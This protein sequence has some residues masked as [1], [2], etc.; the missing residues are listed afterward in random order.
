V[1]FLDTV[2]ALES[3]GVSTFL[4]LGPSAVVTQ[5]IAD[6]VEDAGAA[7]ATLRADR[8][9]PT[10]VVTALGQVFTR[11][12]AVDWSTYFAGARRVDLP[13]YAFQRKRYWPTV[14]LSQPTAAPVVERQ[15]RVELDEHD[16]V[17]REHQVREVI[18][19]ALGTVL[20]YADEE[21]DDHQEFA[22]LGINSLT[23]VELRTRVTAAIGVRLASTA[24]FDHPTLHALTRHVLAGLEQPGAPR[25]TRSPL[26]ALFQ[27]ACAA[28]R[29][30]QGIDLLAA[31]ADIADTTT[32]DLVPPRWVR[33][34]HGANLPPLVCVPSLVAPAS[35]YQFA[36][37]AETFRDLRDLSVLVPS[38]YRG[39]ERLPDSLDTAIRAH[40]DTIGEPSVLVGYSS[41]EPPR[42][43]SCCWT[44]T[45]PAP[46]TSR[47]SRRACTANCPKRTNW[48]SWWTTP[49]SRR[50]AA[51]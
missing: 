45:C 49:R 37:F 5:M 16:V 35:P 39:G 20:G 17:E 47:T 44:A 18:R 32:A 26:V 4:E 11:G 38:G 43:A 3:G 42:S 1:R 31:A 7:V 48:S 9:E 15:R 30:Q 8:P 27:Q 12:V 19:A 34:T 14:D 6:C 33:F 50:W 36:R 22:E 23:A 21:F 2:R 46:G 28:G 40:A 41:G 25:A 24:V 51:T 29:A 13:T 10:A